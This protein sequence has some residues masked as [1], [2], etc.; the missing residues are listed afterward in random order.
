MASDEARSETGWA[1]SQEAVKAGPQPPD[2]T[3]RGGEGGASEQKGGELRATAM[4]AAWGARARMS[5]RRTLQGSEIDPQ[6]VAAA[7]APAVERS[8]AQLKV[9]VVLARGSQFSPRNPSPSTSH[10]LAYIST[11]SSPL[12]ISLIGTELASRVTRRARRWPRRAERRGTAGA[13]PHAELRRGAARYGSL[14]RG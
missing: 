6:I 10:A 1:G 3:R 11:P 12:S 2:A 14:H 5:R 7:C 9:P 13:L 8:A 4:V